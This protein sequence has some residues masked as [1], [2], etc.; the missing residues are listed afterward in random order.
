MRIKERRVL[1]GRINNPN[2]IQPM[3]FKHLFTPRVVLLLPLLPCYSPLAFSQTVIPPSF[4]YPVGA[5]D[6]AAPGFRIKTVQATT[7]AGELPNRISRA[8]AQLSGRLINPVTQLPYVNIANLETFDPEGFFNEETVINYGAIP[9]IPGSEGK[10]DNFAMEAVTYLLLQ[11]ATYTMTVNSDDGFRVTAGRNPD[12][13]L[14]SIGL[15]EYDG[16]RGSADTNFQFTVTA[17]GAYGFRLIYFQGGGGANVRWSLNPTGED[18]AAAAQVQINA[19]DDPGAPEIPTSIKAFRKV[20]AAQPAYAELVTPAPDAT[21]VGATPEL[22]I[23]L[24]DG[25][26]PV[27]PASIQ[28]SL[29]NTPI[30]PAISKTGTKTSVRYQVPAL[31]ASKSVQNVRLSFA[32]T[33]PVPAV[34]TKDYSF[35]VQEYTNIQLP[36][37]PIVEETFDSWA[38]QTSPPAEFT[39]DVLDG[40]EPIPNTWKYH[41]WTVEQYSNSGS[42]WDLN[43]PNSTAFNAWVVL[44]R[45]RTLDIG[46]ADRWEGPRRVSFVAENFVNGVRVPTLMSGNYFYAESDQRGGSQVQYLFSPDFDLTGHTN[47]YLYFHSMYE[48]NQDSV[49]S[50]EYS[51]DQGATWLPILYMIDVVDFVKNDAGE[52]D[53]EATLLK[54]QGDTARYTDPVTFGSKGGYYGA[55][56]GADPATWSTLAPYISGRIN[57]DFTESKRVEFY[58]LPQADNQSKVRFRFAQAGTASWYFGID[59]FALY[60]TSPNDS[61]KPKL[62]VTTVDGKVQLTWPS[63]AVP[64]VL[65][66]A[67]SLSAPV[68]TPVTGADSFGNQKT[69]TITPAAPRAFYRL[70]K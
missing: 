5:V 56:I 26:F 64:Y 23:R 6:A 9:G 60:S 7:S 25:S 63:V 58:R 53:P 54:P 59:N 11:P 32:D 55:F 45:Q 47:T 14:G 37:P 41:G 62:D 1:L 69:K 18:P 22:F 50:V 16:G 29:N 30:T 66:T 4:A 46:V 36:N 15:G 49:A 48:Q 35:T 19:V 24:A 34:T 13:Q 70:R 52:L 20:T 21:R 39:Q 51:V 17:A 33:S 28:L 44:S 8:E 67:A 3:Q 68:W 12:D 61:A 40:L 27:T 10:K 65:E 57:D 43:N 31:L 2:R 42:T 38:E